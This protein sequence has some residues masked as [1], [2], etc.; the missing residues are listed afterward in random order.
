MWTWCLA[1]CREFGWYNRNTALNPFTVEGKKTAA[2]EIAHSMDPVVPDVVVVPVGDGV[3][4]SGVARGFSDL[5]DAG[6]I[7]R[8]TRLLAVQPEGSAAIAAAWAA[9]ADDITPVAG[10]H[11]VADSLTV[12]A[13]RNARMCLQD[14]R[15]TDSKTAGRHMRF[16]RLKWRMW[17]LTA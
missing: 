13:P 11:S 17:L 4:L 5:A 15:R 2:L 3:I 7:E 9:G 6:L 10:A 1:A 12:E 14:L 8:V 16:Q